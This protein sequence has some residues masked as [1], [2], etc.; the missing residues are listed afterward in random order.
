MT[1]EWQVRPLYTYYNDYVHYVVT[2][3]QVKLADITDNFFHHNTTH[4]MEVYTCVVLTIWLRW[5]WQDH[6]SHSLFSVKLPHL[7][8]RLEFRSIG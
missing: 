2:M 3:P 8:G 7:L 6:T 1:D 5:M 4:R